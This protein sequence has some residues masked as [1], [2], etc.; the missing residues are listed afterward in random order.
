MF[1][2][3][4]SMS[5]LGERELW[6]QRTNNLLNMVS[7]YT[8]YIHDWKTSSKTEYFYLVDWRSQHVLGFQ[9]FHVYLEWNWPL[10][11]VT[12][13][14]C[15]NLSPLMIL[16]AFTSENSLLIFQSS[17]RLEI[18]VSVEEDLKIFKRS[19]YLSTY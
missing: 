5:I 18:V 7:C 16:A 11:F 1:S 19:W 6:R 10:S 15:F 17:F 8:V 9:S 3:G 2:D 4:K 13:E 14:F 12:L